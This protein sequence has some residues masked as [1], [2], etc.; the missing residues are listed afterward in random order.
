MKLKYY[1][2]IVNMLYE[3]WDLGKKSSRAKGKTCAWIYWLSLLSEVEQLVIETQDDK[4]IGVSGYTKWSSKKHLFRKK[5]YSILENILI[6]SP[7]VK[8]KKALFQYNKN[9]NYLPKELEGYFDGE[10]TILIVDAAYR[11]KQIGKKLLTKVFDL[12]SKDQMKNLQILTDESC[13]YQFY[14][15]LDC[16]KIYEKLIHNEEKGKLG[17]IPSEMGFIYEKRLVK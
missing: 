6:Y 3:E 16:N 8:D 12:A 13:N 9:Y 17:N 10:V 4:V 14:E 15:K 5:F 2:Q 11:G 1:K 7:L